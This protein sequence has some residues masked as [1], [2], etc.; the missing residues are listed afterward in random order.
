MDVTDSGPTAQERPLQECVA[1][2]IE[3]EAKSGL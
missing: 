2:L 3:A 1:A